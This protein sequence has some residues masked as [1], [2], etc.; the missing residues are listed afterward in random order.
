MSKLLQIIEWRNAGT[1]SVKVIANG[2]LSSLARI[3]FLCQAVIIYIQMY[4]MLV[5]YKDLECRMLN[6][7]IEQIEFCVTN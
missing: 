7:N 3:E 2:R 6:R 4:I 1:P 5:M